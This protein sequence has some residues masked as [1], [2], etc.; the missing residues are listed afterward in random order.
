MLT[1][2]LALRKSF[3]SSL[4]RLVSGFLLTLGTAALAHAQ[5][6]IINTPGGTEIIG[7]RLP[8]PQPTPIPRPAPTAYS[9]TL[10][11]VQGTIRDQAATFQ[12]AQVFKN[13]G[14]ATLEAQLLFPMHEA[15]AISG[16][17]L[18]VDGQELAGKLHPKDEARR[19]YE[20][21]VRQRKDP[22]LLEYVGQGL[23]QTSVFPI[24]AGAERRVEIRYSQ[25][26]KKDTGLIEV[27]LPLGTAKQ[28]QR[29]I[30][31]VAV[32]LRLETTE[33]LKTIFSPTH[34]LEV[35]RTDD[36]HASVQLNLAQVAR[37]DDLRLFFN[38]TGNPVGL[39]VLSYKPRD[40]EDGYF[41]LLATPDWQPPAA[42]QRVPR[43]MLY[44]FDR[45]GSMSGAK[46]EQAKQAL[47]FLVQQLQPEDTFNIVAYDSVVEAFR[48]ELQKGDEAGRNA[49][50]AFVDGLFA[51]GSTNISGALGTGFKLAGDTKRPTYLLFM[52]DGLPTVGEMNE[53]KIADQVKSANTFG[54]RLF[55][56]GVGYDVN[57]RLLDRLSGGHRGQ[58]VYV[59]PNENIER[60]VAGLYN[61][62]G[63]PALTDIAVRFDFDIPTPPGSAGPV[64]RTYPRN[65]NDLYHGDQLVY[66]G[67]YKTGGTA[68][69]VMSG[70][71]SETG[72]EYI[73]A[74]SFVEKSMDETNAFVERLWAQRRIGEIIDELD[75][76]GA[77][78]ELVTELVQLSLRHGILTPYTSFLADETTALGDRVTQVREAE[79][80]SRSLAE[81]TSGR[82]GFVQRGIKGR[83]QNESLDGV[84]KAESR[85]ESSRPALA[86]QPQ[87]GVPQSAGGVAAASGPVDKKIAAPAPT[88]GK[89]VDRFDAA[90]RRKS[91]SLA[92]DAEGNTKEVDTLRQV[93][94]KTFHRRQ[95]VWLECEISQERQDKAEKIV[96]FSTEYFHLVD[97]YG[98][99]I[100]KYLDFDEPVVVELGGRVY[101]IEPAKE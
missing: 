20:N 80:L 70:K 78:E 50:L 88:L 32:K 43:T 54:A 71:M 59:R 40:N 101:R 27:L 47:K 99:K 100:A 77:N 62:I 53:L 69:I 76:R 12:L 90:G 7:R 25:L 16:L 98:G 95:N 57:S 44:V 66:V 11:E 41:A 83:F 15:A 73:A 14:S 30:E 91:Y 34:T 1:N 92:M 51:G 2:P 84:A 8:L 52:T 33:P 6:I 87:A 96:K 35:S 67:R 42:A 29:A 74:A 36:R 81:N 5:V 65:L 10:L 61:K 86:A 60:A 45:S 68:K 85:A 97:T 93:G 13:T 9:V 79:R 82:A 64:S 89:S 38:T 24:P 46:F 56:F 55:S 19:I 3:Q 28:H 22:A 4:L 21:I 75:L 39:S 37:P 49:A 94:A 63:S 72:K 26:L 17:T 31:R 58:S 18:L 23:Y 48:P